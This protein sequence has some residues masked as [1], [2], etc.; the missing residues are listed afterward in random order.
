M[1]IGLPCQLSIRCDGRGN[2]AKAA[3]Q[4]KLFR[5]FFPKREAQAAKKL[6]QR[7]A[8]QISEAAEHEE[9]HTSIF[10]LRSLEYSAVRTI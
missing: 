3:L 10:D 6:F 7:S 5:R 9:P 8:Q 2:A 4:T 1:V